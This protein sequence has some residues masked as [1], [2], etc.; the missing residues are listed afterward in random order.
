MNREFS[1]VGIHYSSILWLALRKGLMRILYVSV[2]IIL[3]IS[4]PMFLLYLFPFPKVFPPCVMDWMA[5]LLFDCLVLHAK[6]S[7]LLRVM[8]RLDFQR[9]IISQT[10]DQ[11][12]IIDCHYRA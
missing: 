6:S 9:D 1:L 2:Y 5:S 11:S 10:S 3:V 12:K 8:S 4:L 7:S